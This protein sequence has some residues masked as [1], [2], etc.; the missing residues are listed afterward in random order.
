MPD[1]EN[2]LSRW[3]SAGLIDATLAA[4]L[5][6]HESSGRERSGMQLQVLIALILGGILLAAGVALFVNA[7][8]DQISPLSR[9]LLV[10]AMV[11]V[12]HI[13]G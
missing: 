2:Y 10:M 5:R 8:W 1:L 6:E 13:G 11:C 7:H 9:Y 12:F 3:Q 4:R